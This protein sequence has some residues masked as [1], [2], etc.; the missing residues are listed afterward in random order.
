MPTSSFPPQPLKHLRIVFLSRGGFLPQI[1]QWVLAP[2]GPRVKPGI[3][4]SLAVNAKQPLV[5]PGRIRE[6]YRITSAHWEPDPKLVALAEWMADYY[7]APAG[8]CWLLSNHRTSPF[9]GSTRWT[10]T[11]QG[12]QR[13]K[14]AR[15]GTST[16]TLLAAL[17]KRPQR[18]G[19]INH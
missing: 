3:I 13:L 4:V 1:G 14:T 2:F 11:Q 9:A 17:A 16:H 19:A 10:I 15:T 6:L 12:Q 18:P 7:L 5:D 8:T